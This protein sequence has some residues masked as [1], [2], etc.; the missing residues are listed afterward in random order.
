MDFVLVLQIL[1]TQFIQMFVSE[2]DEAVA[3]FFVVSI[4]FCCGELIVEMVGW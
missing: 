2:K 1:V 3:V 4:L